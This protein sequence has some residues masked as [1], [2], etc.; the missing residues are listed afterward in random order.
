MKKL[1]FIPILAM[2]VVALQAQTAFNVN[3]SS[4]V[5]VWTGYKVT[6]KHTGTVKIKS[7]TLQFTDGMLTAGNF[8]LDMTTVK[9][10]DLEGEWAAKL[11]GHLKSDDFLGVEQHPTSTL[12]VTR[13]IPQDSKGNY[14]V[15]GNLTIKGITK[16]IKFF[17]NVQEN[18]GGISATGK[19]TIDRSEYNMRYGSGSFFDGLGDK[20]IYDEFDLEVSL[21]ASK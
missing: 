9:D 10:T 7:G 11:E 20:T 14:K 3:T 1:L 5:V 21:V 2:F 4:S 17:A 15:I 6:G 18:K 19:L 16:E 12:T 13:A 8:E